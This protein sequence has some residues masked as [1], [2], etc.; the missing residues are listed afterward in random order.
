M[1]SYQIKAN[2]EDLWFNTEREKGRI[3]LNKCFGKLRT[4][5]EKINS[6][7]LVNLSVL[8]FTVKP[9]TVKKFAIKALS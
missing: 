1:K 3:R 6:C 4:E 2:K 9:G 8:F 7:A 5:K